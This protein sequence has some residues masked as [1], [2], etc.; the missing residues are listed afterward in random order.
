MKPR[1]KAAPQTSP[2]T[3]HITFEIGEAYGGL[4]ARLHDTLA[5]RKPAS[6]DELARKHE[7]P[8]PFGSLEIGAL[9]ELIG[10][11][12]QEVPHFVESRLM[13]V[14]LITNGGTIFWNLSE[15]MIKVHCFLLYFGKNISNFSWDGWP[16]FLEKEEESVKRL[17]E[18]VELKRQFIASSIIHL[19]EEEVARLHAHLMWLK[20]AEQSGAHLPSSPPATWANRPKTERGRGLNYRTPSRFIVETYAAAYHAGELGEDDVHRLDPTLLRAYK[21]RISHYPDEALPLLKPVKSEADRI[22]DA[23]DPIVSRETV[24]RA[25]RAKLRTEQRKRSSEPSIS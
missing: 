17:F 23:I 5:W 1:R 4:V 7:G 20:P 3:G 6:L 13:P 16:E 18:A 14:P 15:V 19:S 21:Q 2:D 10:R 11:D 24:I 9:S 25:V 12:K 8:M 22:L